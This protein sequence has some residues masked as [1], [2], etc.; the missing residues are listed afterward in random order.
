MSADATRGVSRKRSLEEL[1]S[2]PQKKAKTGSHFGVQYSAE[3]ANVPPALTA[4]PASSS[5]RIVENPIDW[6]TKV[7][8]HTPA[9]PVVAPTP[10]AQFL[11]N[12]PM[13]LQQGSQ[14]V[15]STDAPTS[16]S[17]FLGGIPM[18]TFHLY[19]P[20]DDPLPIDDNVA[21]YS[22]FPQ[23]DCNNQVYIDDLESLEKAMDN[24][25]VKKMALEDVPPTHKTYCELGAAYL[26]QRKYPKAQE[27]FQKAIQLDPNYTRA[28]LGLASYFFYVGEY[29]KTIDLCL[30]I[31]K[32]DKYWNSIQFKIGCCY[33]KLD[34]LPEAIK[35]FS[36]VPE[37]NDLFWRAQHNIGCCYYNQKKYAEAADHFEKATSLAST[38]RY[39]T[40]TPKLNPGLYY[41]GLC[42]IALD[43]RE[44][45]IQPF[46]LIPAKSH[47]SPLAKSKLS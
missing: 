11:D 43:K 38:S 13:Q 15:V 41:L 3:A 44:M 22:F 39:S 2:R 37:W 5:L 47:Y 42:Y 6:G 26:A 4:L 10:G 45:A 29:A 8:E 21:P 9:T 35:Y 28:K 19:Q 12:I 25:S 14:E 27:N 30:P 36:L 23:I 16:S 33:L 17:Q 1:D 34:N 46:S 32:A 18:A 20:K 24:L 31:E 40:H 7:L